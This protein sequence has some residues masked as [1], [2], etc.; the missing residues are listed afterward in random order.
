MSMLLSMYKMTILGCLFFLVRNG[1]TQ[2]AIDPNNL[3][4]K[5]NP[6]MVF[7]VDKPYLQANAEWV[8][9]ERIGLDVGYGKRFLD[10]WILDSQFNERGPDSAAVRF[11]GTLYSADLRYYMHLLPNTSKY[12]DYLFLALSYRHIDDLRNVSLR[13]LAPDAD[14][15]GNVGTEIFIDHCAVQRKLDL[16]TLKFGGIFEIDRFGIEGFIELGSNRKRQ[17]YVANELHEAGYQLE[18]DLYRT[19]PVPENTI[20]PYLGISFRLSYRIW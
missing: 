17:V 5:F 13:Y 15:T 10:N 3:R 20:K 4:V 1:W 12:R 14:T 6:G 2:E 16:I 19:Q 9:R 11:N 7:N 18:G 8:F